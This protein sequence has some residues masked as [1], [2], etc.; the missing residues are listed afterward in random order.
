MQDADIALITSLRELTS[1]VIES[2]S[3]G[4]PVV[5]LDH[6][7]FSDVIDESCGIKVPVTNFSKI[8][9]TYQTPFINYLR[10]KSY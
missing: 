6:C 8:Q 1:T 7:G 4:L 10:I 2:L 9:T 5:C 3:L